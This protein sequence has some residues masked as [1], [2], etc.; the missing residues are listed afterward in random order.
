MTCPCK[1]NSVC[2]CYLGELDEV[3]PEVIGENF[4]WLPGGKQGGEEAATAIATEALHPAKS[5]QLKM[6]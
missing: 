4:C 2:N 3:A 6:G 5:A 1:L